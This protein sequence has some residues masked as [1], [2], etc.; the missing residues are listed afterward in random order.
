MWRAFV[1]A[2]EDNTDRVKQ[3]YNQFVPLDGKFADNVLVQI[4][5][6]PLDFIPREAFS[7]LFGAMPQTRLMMELQITQEYLSVSNQLAYLAPLY[8]EVL[9]QDTY[10]QGEG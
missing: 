9:D 2:F 4:K 6:G 10:A 5:N 8:E 1:Y 7:P 3:A